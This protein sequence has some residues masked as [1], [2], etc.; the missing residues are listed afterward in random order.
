VARLNS[1]TSALPSALQ[2]S[3]TP[4]V[5]N[6]TEEVFRIKLDRHLLEI[7][8]RFGG[9]GC[10]SQNPRWH[11]NAQ[12]TA[13]QRALALVALQFLNSK[14]QDGMAVDSLI[15]C[16]DLATQCREIAELT[17]LY[18]LPDAEEETLDS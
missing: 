12:H 11:R 8:G 18:N 7:I 15:A 5:K 16:R 6:T 3:R 4:Q 14:D 10:H 17:K 9:V 2:S 1:T 13:I